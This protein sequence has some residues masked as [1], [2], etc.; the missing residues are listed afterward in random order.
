MATFDVET[1]QRKLREIN[2]RTAKLAWPSTCQMNLHLLDFRLMKD[3]QTPAGSSRKELNHYT[4][5]F[6]EKTKNGAVPKRILVH[7][8]PGI[9]KSTFV[10]KLLLDWSDPKKA[11]MDEKRKDALRK[12]ELGLLI[13]LRKV[14]KCQTLREILSTTYVFSEDEEASFD[15]LPDYICNNQEKVLLVLDGYDEYRYDE[16]ESRSNSPIYNIFQG[17][18]LRD[19]TVLITTRSS[20]TDELQGFADIC[21]QMETIGFNI[22]YDQGNDSHVFFSSLLY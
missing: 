3:E 4:E 21:V 7:G 6:S 5:L 14:S 1:C 17:N 18:N 12:F 11:K 8:V 15:N 22:S 19:C 16:Y 9:G 2:V 13:K 20:H 10:K